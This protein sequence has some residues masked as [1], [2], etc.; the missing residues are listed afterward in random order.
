MCRHAGFL[1]LDSQSPQLKPMKTPGV[2]VTK[3]VSF[4]L[5]ATAGLHDAIPVQY[6]PDDGSG[7]LCSHSQNTESSTHMLKTPI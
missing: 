7:K 6:L 3:V 4:K 5:L 2:G 1:Q